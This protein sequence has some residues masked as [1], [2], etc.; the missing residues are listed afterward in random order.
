[1]TFDLSGKTALVT[2]A[3]RGIGYFLAQHLA[4]AGAHVIAVARTEGGLTELDDAVRAEGGSATLVPL[5][6][7]D[8]DGI[9]RLG[10]AIYE[11]WGKL[12]IMVSNAGILGTLTPLGHIK[13]KDFESVMA[14]NVTAG[15]RLVRAMDV[16][17]RASDAA[18]VVF[19]SSGAVRRVRPFWGAYA[20]SKA[21]SDTMAVTYA[22][23]LENTPHRVNLFNPGG[24][25]TAMRAKAMPGED[26][27]SLPSA[28]EVSAGMMPLF[29]PDLTET[30]RLYDFRAG[31][32][33][34][35][36]SADS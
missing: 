34:P 36:A 1:M 18:R 24:T 17:L 8:Y 13:P 12:D 32:F 35:E 7:K 20:M 10:G 4:R 5:D 30:G 33:V 31:G 15:W 19:L 11:R 22:R 25:R 14:V 26:P 21:A 2:G 16:L 27:A 23:E 3:S 9:D 29:A 6:L 28:N